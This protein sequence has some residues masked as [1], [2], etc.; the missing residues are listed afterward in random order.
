MLAG[1][2]SAGKLTRTADG[3]RV[4][5]S[6]GAIAAREVVIATNGYTGSLTPD[7]RRRLVPVAS[8]IIATE[9][10][11]P[12]LARSLIPQGRTLADTRRVLC[13]WRCRRTAR[14]CC[15]GPRPV[16]PGPAGRLRPALH[17]MMLDRW[18][19]LRG[20]R[21][22]HA[23]TGNVAF[24]FDYLPHTGVTGQGLHYAMAC[25]GSG[26]SMLSYLGAKVGRK[27]LGGV[28]QPTA[29]E[30]RD[31]PTKPFYNGHPW[32]LPAVVPITA[33][34][35]GSTGATPHKG[36]A[37]MSLSRRG[38]TTAAGALLLARG[39]ERGRAAKPAQIVVNHSGGS[40]GSAMRKAFFN[41]FEKKY[42]IQVV[43]TSPADFGKLRAMVDS[44]NVE[45]DVTEIGGQD[46]IRA[47]KIG[48]VEKIDD[49]IVDRS[50]YPEKARTPYVFA[51]S[52]YTTIIGYRTDVFKGGTQ[53]KSWADWW[54]VK[55]FPGAR[56][57]RNHPTDNL[58]F[59][60][61]AD[62]VPMDKLYPDRLRPRLQE[63]RPDQAARHG[64]V[65]DRPAAGP[66]AARQG[67]RAGDRLERPLLR[68]HQEGRAGR[69]RVERRAR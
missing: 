52:V 17:G 10:L 16:H 23:W 4:E 32:F 12:G 63:A 48:L 14:G 38:F 57:M 18:P 68:P 13:Y 25:N 59:A 34:A 66:A 20:V 24:A 61:I 19:Q 6:R 67:G 41:G 29:F 42:G 44:G 50:K 26:V 53:P 2:T 28:N 51:S 45:W 47:V 54:D 60:L 9:P 62:G 55:K 11:E 15:S 58:E 22:T 39:G 8:H 1:K 36:R 21:I 49:K 33:C 37:S 69:D 35:T 64:M 56:S 40:M 5:T 3:W 30:G 31:F 7:L 65:V 46:A 43:E 27:L